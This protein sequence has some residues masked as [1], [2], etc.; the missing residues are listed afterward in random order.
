MSTFPDSA[1][2]IAAGLA[3]REF[4]SVEVTSAFLDRIDS[5]DKIYNSFISVTRAYAL[6]Q[7]AAAD[8]A[9][10]DGTAGQMTGVPYAHKD[11]F[12]TAGTK[13]TCGSRM[14]DNF[15]APYNATV[16]E[17]LNAAG[18]VMLLAAPLARQDQ[19]GRVCHGLFE[20]NELLRPRN[21]PV[22]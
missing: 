17:R 21:Q 11:I 9:I 2:G 15:T 14:L 8:A 5:R 3:A 13:T 10:A 16:S 12:C 1:A 19:H 22:A 7:A 6:E 20:R 18:M 4:S